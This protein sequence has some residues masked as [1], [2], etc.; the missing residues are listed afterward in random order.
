MLTL[1]VKEPL[2]YHHSPFLSFHC[3]CYIPLHV[4]LHKVIGYVNLWDRVYGVHVCAH[5]L[6]VSIYLS[7][8]VRACVFQSGAQGEAGEDQP[9]KKVS[10]SLHYHT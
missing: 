6:C 3:C 9:F 4:G 5:S 8:C 10:L 7:V 2:P 1:T